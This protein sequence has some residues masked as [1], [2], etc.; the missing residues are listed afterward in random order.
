MLDALMPHFARCQELVVRASDYPAIQ[1]MLR[2]LT[3]VQASK[4]QHVGLRVIYEPILQHSLEEPTSV[5]MNGLPALRSIQLMGVPF[6]CVTPLAGLTSLDLRGLILGQMEYFTTEDDIQILLG[7]SHTSLARLVLH[8]PPWILANIL[9]KI[10][11]P[12]LKFLSVNFYACC[13]PLVALFVALN[14]RALECLES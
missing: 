11:F 6:K 14:L 4:L 2:P 1:G 12:A 13:N 3:D 8:R 9:L 5:I 10:D 7:A